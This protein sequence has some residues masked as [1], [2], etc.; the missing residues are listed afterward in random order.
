MTKRKEVS[1]RN[2]QGIYKELRI[3]TESAEPKWVETGRYRAIRRVRGPNGRS[4]KEQQM[5]DH[6][7]MARAFRYGGANAGQALQP[8][9]PSKPRITFEELIKEWQPF[10]IPSLMPAY[11]SVRFP[12]KPDFLGEWSR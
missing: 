5:F 2:H 6:L 10:R 7:E 12:V 4:R 3:D 1:V 11:N 8:V 9:T